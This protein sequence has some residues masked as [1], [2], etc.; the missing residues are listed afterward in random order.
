[1]CYVVVE[2][3]AAGWFDDVVERRRARGAERQN[4]LGGLFGRA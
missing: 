1:M 4:F 3:R 2:A